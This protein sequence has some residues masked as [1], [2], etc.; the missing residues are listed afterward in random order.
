[1]H[2]RFLLRSADSIRV[3]RAKIAILQ[4][5]VSAETAP[6]LIKEFMVCTV[7]PLVPTRLTD[8]CRQQYARSPQVAVS[9][10]AINAVGYC[11]RTQPEVHTLGLGI[12]MKMLRSNR[13]E[14]DGHST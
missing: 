8:F 6:F 5:L 10:E 13:G 12:L 11:A 2:T 4:R 14:P 9:T 3:K 7:N 1:M